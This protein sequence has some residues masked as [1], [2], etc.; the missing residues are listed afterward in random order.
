MFKLLV[1]TAVVSLV[2]ILLVLAG[3]TLNVEMTPEQVT[4]Q[5]S[6]EE[7]AP[8]IS[9]PVNL[10]IIG[11][12]DS[13]LNS[14]ILSENGKALIASYGVFKKG[15]VRTGS[16]DGF[17]VIYLAR[18]EITRTARTEI[19]RRVAAGA[20]LIIVQDGGYTEDDELVP[21]N[22]ELG[23]YIPVKASVSVYLDPIS[24]YQVNGNLVPS[25]GLQQSKLFEGYTVPQEV[26]TWTLYEV[27]PNSGSEE[28]GFI[29][30]TSESGA[31]IEHTAILVK[32]NHLAGTVLYFAYKPTQTPAI[33][34]NAIDMVI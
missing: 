32:Y 5:K 7:T 8:V 30:Q 4:I 14:V 23:N 25:P 24:T 11:D 2:I 13:D 28:T 3:I 6:V 1:L 34:L 31:I 9:G 22:T 19:T 15:D 29:E 12:V 20:G 33:L 21:W 26:D 17:Q 16:L 27:I 18:N 10:A